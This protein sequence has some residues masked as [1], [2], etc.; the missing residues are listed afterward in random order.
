MFDQ[1]LYKAVRNRQHELLQVAENH[2][3]IEAT[4]AKRPRRSKYLAANLGHF[5][6]I[7][8]PWLKTQYRSF[9]GDHAASF[10]KFEVKEKVQ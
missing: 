2:R 8:G 3:L 4:R 7:L 5:L 6:N 1:A 10:I 9:R